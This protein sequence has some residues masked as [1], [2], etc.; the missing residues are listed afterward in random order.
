MCINIL[1]ADD[2]SVNRMLLEKM[3]TKL[4]VSC[5]SAKDGGEVLEIFEPRKFDI[6]ILDINMPVYSGN[7]CAKEIIKRCVD[8]SA[9]VPLLVS[10][11]ADDEYS[12]HYLFYKTLSKPFDISMIKDMIN[13][14]CDFVKN[15]QLYDL[16]AAAEEIGFDHETMLML[17]EE[18]VKAVDEEITAL[19]KALIDY[20]G[21]MITHLAHKIKGAAANMRMERLRDICSDL[22]NIEKNDNL[23]TGRLIC[24]LNSA[25]NAI[26]TVLVS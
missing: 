6:V 26:R 17:T 15:A 21:D 5:V 3:I 11:S 8:C 20:D 9:G 22:Q 2:T 13:F 4:G 7:E 10:M 14:S 24:E 23:T 18:F 16:D 19:N 25:Y 12:D 1:I